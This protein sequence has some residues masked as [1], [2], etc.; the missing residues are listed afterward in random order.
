VAHFHGWDKIA[1]GGPAGPAGPR[2]RHCCPTA[3]VRLSL[4]EH[5]PAWLLPLVNA[6]ERSYDRKPARDPWERLIRRL[7]VARYTA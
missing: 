5:A 6:V 1:G 7:L 3:G 2:R 4:D